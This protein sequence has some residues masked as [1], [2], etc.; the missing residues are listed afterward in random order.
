MQ[1]CKDK[2]RTK[3]NPFLLFLYLPRPHVRAS[4][5]CSD[6]PAEAV[7]GA[8]QLPQGPAAHLRRQQ[9]ATS[10]SPHRRCDRT[11]TCTVNYWNVLRIYVDVSVKPQ[12]IAP[13]AHVLVSLYFIL[14]C[15]VVLLL[16]L[17]APCIYYKNMS[18]YITCIF[19]ISIHHVSVLFPDE[20]RVYV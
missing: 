11:Y 9:G 17:N 15:C 3:R 14:A 10:A 2:T 19:S 6:Q 1:S 16:L 13:C 12:C 8:R 7:H 4:V 20:P 5:C 18:W